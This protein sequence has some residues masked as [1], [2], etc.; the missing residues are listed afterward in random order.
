MLMVI[1]RGQ[2]RVIAR[3]S[4]RGM[5]MFDTLLSLMVLAVIV[6]GAAEFIEKERQRRANGIEIDR[7]VAL[8]DLGERYARQDLTT[9]MDHLGAGRIA[10]IS[11]DD[12]QEAGL[13]SDGL[14]MSSVATR[15]LSLWFY[16]PSADELMVIA[17]ATG[18]REMVNIPDL[19]SGTKQIGYVPEFEPSRVMGVGLNWDVS[20]LQAVSAVQAGDR[21]PAVNDLIAVRY[22]N[23]VAD[24]RPYLHREPVTLADGTQ[25]NRMDAPLDMGGHNIIGTGNVQAG[26]AAFD[27]VTADTMV[28]N[29]LLTSDRMAVQQNLDITGAVTALEGTIAGP[30]STG[31]LAVT[32]DVTANSLAVVNGITAQ[33]A[34][35]TDRLTADAV[36]ITGTVI[37]DHVVVQS[38]TAAGDIRSGGR[39]VFQSITTGSCLGC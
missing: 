9:H 1:R 19:V 22:L 30:V 17:R 2:K 10:S 16:M 27:T 39:G 34:E 23:Q 26:A 25:M 7:V 28:V 31:T 12:L 32:N 8:A 13:A 24:V 21:F 20:T 35:V 14:I 37:S 15:D 29:G 36:T 18:E 33:S 11:V 38:L 4:R 5:G 6:A 3:R